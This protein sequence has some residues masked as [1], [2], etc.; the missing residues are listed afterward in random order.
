LEFIYPEWPSNRVQK[1]VQQVFENTAVTFL[2]ISRFASFSK[3]DILA[4]V[5][6]R[7]EEYLRTALEAPDGLIMISA[8]LGNWEMGHLAVS[9]YRNR[10]MLLVARRIRPQIL[11][12]RLNQIRQTFGNSVIDKK[13]ALPKMARR[14]H[15]KGILGLLI[16]QEPKHSRGIQ[17]TFFGKPTSTTPGPALLARRYGSPILPVF[18]VRETDGSLTLSVERPILPVKTHDSDADL[19]ENV[20][21]MTRAVEAAVRAHPEQWFWF[22]KRWKHEFPHLYKEDLNR[23]K[24]R[25]AKTRKA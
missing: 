3:K 22:H 7:G 8:H 18:C 20:Q 14:L 19:R 17:V 15:Q 23:L 12:R 13:R 24:R 25:R 4:S 16:D 11:N 6:V 10:S 2:E 21:A 9:C 5:Q 1:T